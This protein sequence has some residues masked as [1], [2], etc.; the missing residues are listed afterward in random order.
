M[1]N[2]KKFEADHIRER[3]VGVLKKSAVR[4]EC[5]DSLQKNLDI[6]KLDMERS[7]MLMDTYAS[8]TEQS[9]CM[10]SCTQ[11]MVPPAD[12]KQVFVVMAALVT[13]DTEEDL[14]EI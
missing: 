5:L 14:N 4:K 11:G 7:Q 10:E 13:F 9:A 1:Y 8:E 12:T 2:Y 6:L 3:C